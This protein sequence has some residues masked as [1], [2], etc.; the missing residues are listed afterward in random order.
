LLF[1]SFG[2]SCFVCHNMPPISRPDSSESG[3]ESVETLNW[4]G[5]R[6]VGLRTSHL[7]WN[8]DRPLQSGRCNLHVCRE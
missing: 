1:L 2:Q 4:A 5:S 6:P 8:L 7:R 3:P